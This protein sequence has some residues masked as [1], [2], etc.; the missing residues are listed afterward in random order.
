ML[1]SVAVSPVLSMVDEL[2][3]VACLLVYVV[4]VTALSIVGLDQLPLHSLSRVFV[5]FV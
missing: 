4:S 5:Q 2:L 1:E 3:G